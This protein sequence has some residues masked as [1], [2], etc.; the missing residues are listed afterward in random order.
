MLEGQA[1]IVQLAVREHG[2]EIRK[3]GRCDQQLAQAFLGAQVG[4]GHEVAGSLHADL[5]VLDLAEV[6]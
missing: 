6:A 2:A 4:L 3:P 1:D 5:E